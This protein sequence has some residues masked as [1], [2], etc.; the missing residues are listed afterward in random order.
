MNRFRNILTIFVLLLIIP[1]F[2]AAEDR[3]VVEKLDQAIKT[4]QEEHAIPV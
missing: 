3:K 1:L 2:L 4:Y